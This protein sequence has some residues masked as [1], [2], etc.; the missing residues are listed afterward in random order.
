MTTIAI[1][2]YK[3]FLNAK[4]LGLKT[5]KAELS[6]KAQSYF[7]D[8]TRPHASCQNVLVYRLDNTGV[9]CFD[10]DDKSSNDFLTDIMDKHNI[11]NNRTKSVSNLFNPDEGENA[12]K[13]HY[14]FKTDKKIDKKL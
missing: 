12:H 2:T 10:A 1:P 3:G 8:T 6:A 5:A 11:T 9:V 7:K 4:K 14:L 13:F